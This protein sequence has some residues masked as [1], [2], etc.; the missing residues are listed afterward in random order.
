[1][2][3]A[4]HSLNHRGQVRRLASLARSALRAYSLP[5][6]RLRILAHS[7]TTT[8]RVAA[9][10]GD[11]YVL[12]VLPVSQSAVEPVRS[13]LLWL[14]ALWED[15][16]PVPEPV[17]NQEQRL[18][19]WATDPGVP[20]PRLCVLLRWIEGR[21]LYLRL[22]PAHL[23]QAGDLMARLHS[24]AAHWSRPPGFTRHRI[25]HLNLTECGQDVPFD[26]AAA[27]RAIQ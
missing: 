10:S 24:H 20:E 5:G 7:W 26:P 25:D 13:E 17:L 3:P 21:C 4:F 22:T 11:Q 6:V 16:L 12:R 23:A 8:S 27:E 15:G 1:M 18:V 9:A 2:Q 19:T 14:A